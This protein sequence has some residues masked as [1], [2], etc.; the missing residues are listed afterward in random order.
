MIFFETLL[1]LNQNLITN[2]NNNN[3][4]IITINTLYN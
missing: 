1:T 4:I 3:N 2:N